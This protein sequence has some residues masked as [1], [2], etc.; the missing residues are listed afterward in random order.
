LPVI[1]DGMQHAGD[2]RTVDSV[3][4]WNQV[5]RMALFTCRGN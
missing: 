5:R 2:R 3:N 4:C 1:D